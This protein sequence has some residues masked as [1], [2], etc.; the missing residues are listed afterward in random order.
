[1][2]WRDVEQKENIN[3]L[4]EHGRARGARRQFTLLLNGSATLPG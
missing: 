3:S 1:M 2:N 4:D